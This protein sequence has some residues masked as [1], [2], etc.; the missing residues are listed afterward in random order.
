M[1]F[2]GKKSEKDKE[3]CLE[4]FELLKVLGRGAFGKVILA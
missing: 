2:T 4:D 1:L 3:V